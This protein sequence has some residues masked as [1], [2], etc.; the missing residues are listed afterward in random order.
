MVL[1]QT[2]W[3]PSSYCRCP[4]VARLQR[5]YP[6]VLCRGICPFRAQA[7]GRLT[8]VAQSSQL[9]AESPGPA[10]T[11]SCLAVP[12]RR[13]TSMGVGVGRQKYPAIFRIT[14]FTQAPGLPSKLMSLNSPSLFTLQCFSRKLLGSSV[15]RSLLSA[16]LTITSPLGMSRTQC[17][18]S[19][20]SNQE[21]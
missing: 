8:P 15:S 3:A 21:P 18:H 19:L 10:G 5:S 4:K 1:P 9:D 6:C 17:I 2:P 16:P 11:C 12:F 14:P 13:Q 20:G 7:T